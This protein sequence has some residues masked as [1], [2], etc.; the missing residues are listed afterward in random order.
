MEWLQQ[1]IGSILNQ[2]FKDFEFIIVCD[3]P[4]YEEGKK[5]L[6]EY[7]QKDER[8]VL[9]FNEENI[10]LT[11][12]LNKGLAIAK[13]EYIARM[14]ADDI[15]LSDR[16]NEQV[17]FMSNHSDVDICHTDYYNINEDGDLIKSKRENKKHI[18][19]DLLF[20][21]NVVA[22]PT[23]MMKRKCLSFRQPL[24]NEKIRIGQ[25]Y[26]L[27]SF[28]CIRDLKFGYLNKRLMQ[29]RISRS[30]ISTKRLNEQHENTL[31]IRREFIG[32]FLKKLNIIDE[33]EGYENIVDIE[34]ISKIKCFLRENNCRFIKDSLLRI[35]YILYYTLACNNAKYV[36]YFCSEQKMWNMIF[37]VKDYLRLLIAPI[38]GRKLNSMK[39]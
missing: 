26:E 18:N 29:Y 5:L 38:M 30:Q 15:A 11:K 22:H 39:F 25:D 2:T 16:F 12:S 37:G 8:I 14:D 7:S 35:M 34:C 3:N 28:L 17:D 33:K 20:W 27:W 19:H 6:K 23:V 31:S 9:I 1:S 36:L 10:G 13:G 21:Y 32:S 4:D 24:Y